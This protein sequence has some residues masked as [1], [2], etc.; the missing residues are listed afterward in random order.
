MTV[1]SDA[2]VHH[3]SAVDYAK[4]GI[5]PGAP[6]TRPP[7]A[8]RI[9][10]PDEHASRVG[11][12]TLFVFFFLFY[13]ILG[14]W[15]NL[16]GN[17]IWGDAASR[18]ADASYVV[19]SRYPH[20]G[21]IGFVWNP[22]P[23]LLDIPLILARDIWAPLMTRGVAA[24]FVTAAFAAGAVVAIRGI[25]IDRGLPRLPRYLLV[26]LF[27]FHPMIV[28][29]SI[30]GMTEMDQLFMVLWVIRSLFRWVW[31][32]RTTSLMWAG[33]G[34]AMCY[35]VRY[36][37]AA[38][39]GGATLFVLIV[40]YRRSKE[41]TRRARR[42]DAITDGLVIALPFVVS[43]IAWATA[44]WILTGTAFAQF[45]SVYGN[46]N[47]T[48][49]VAG[50]GGYG[51]INAALGSPFILPP[52]DILAMEFLLPAIVVVAVVLGWRRRDATPWVL[53][54]TCGTALVFFTLTYG[55]KLTFPWFRFYILAVP[56]AVLSVGSFWPDVRSP[57]TVRTSGLQGWGA[58]LLPVLLLGPALPISLWGMLNPSIGFQ[59]HPLA[60]ILNPSANSVL[61]YA[62]LAPPDVQTRLAQYIASLNLPNG[63]VL[64]DTF[65]GWQIFLAA[66]D[67]KTYVITS[68][69][70]FIRDL[71]APREFGVKYVLVP[72]PP[73]AW[74]TNAVSQRYPSMWANGAGIGAQVLFAPSV[75]T[76]P[77]WKL[78]RINGVSGAPLRSS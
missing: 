38:I 55:V 40:S 76:Q 67:N 27:A 5:E 7:I 48:K 56:L 77:A 73:A 63:S 45:T 61:N 71:N 1:L 66:H 70:D 22:L 16:K 60:A 24:I 14:L 12:V 54:S 4:A 35:L 51:G 59:E 25:L 28:M 3:P 37:S 68:D 65:T 21:A 42:V 46:D 52:R 2:R 31:D 39:A 6:I 58:L 47:Q 69:F 15:L 18:V 10:G 74:P 49:A 41:P 57:R 9:L 19:F 33:V 78:Y 23:S 43:F 50:I 32:D 64:M 53:L 30:N 11:G 34:L 36:E 13:L 62:D 20:L 72:G 75:G 17:W 44:S 29:Y 26:L 8:Q